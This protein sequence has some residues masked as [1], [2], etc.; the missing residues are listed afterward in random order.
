MAFLPT[1]SS[2]ALNPIAYT[3]KGS[4]YIY[5]SR[6]EELFHLNKITIYIVGKIIFYLLTECIIYNGYTFDLSDSL[7]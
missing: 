1:P 3:S 6:Y 7:L 5:P 2:Q 4:E